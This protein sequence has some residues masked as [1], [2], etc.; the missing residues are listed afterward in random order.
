M[1]DGEPIVA[2]RPTRERGPRS[3]HAHLKAVEPGPSAV[4][5]DRYFELTSGL[6]CAISLDGRL[7]QLSRSWTDLLGWPLDELL[8]RPYVELVHPDDVERT[9]HA[10]DDLAVGGSLD[11]FENRY[12]HRNGSYRWLRWSA[13][14]HPE[15]GQVYAVVHDV[16]EERRRQALSDEL[17]LVTGVGTWEL[18]LAT[19]MMHA[20]P[21]AHALH[22]TDP[23]EA[24]PA[25]EGLDFY[26]SEHRSQVEADYLGLV[27]QG[28]PFDRELPL[29]SRDGRRRW[30][31]STGRAKRRDGRVVRA[32]GTIQDITGSYEER[33]RLRHF[34]DLVELSQEGIVEVGADGV[35]RVA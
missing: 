24:I 19:R 35:I 14:H 9:R 34:E 29:I 6:L 28:I 21:V 3:T 20:S 8:G 17:E 4:R 23:S 7:L 5:F 1:A 26:P 10:A 27:T 33:A 12:R 15:D 32:Y 30:V 22:G 25:V 11:G 13:V 16:T 2:S 31:R 18:D